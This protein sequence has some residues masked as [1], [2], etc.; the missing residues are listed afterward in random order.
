MNEKRCVDCLYFEVRT[1]F[2]RYAPPIPVVFTSE[3]QERDENGE[4]YNTIMSKA[5]AKFPT[6]KKPEMDYCWQFA[7]KLLTE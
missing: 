5:R 3:I 4:Y 2:C 1:N 7:D 6:I